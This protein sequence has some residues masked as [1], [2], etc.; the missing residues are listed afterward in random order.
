MLD[1]RFG[2][3]VVQLA[4]EARLPIVVTPIRHGRVEHLLRRRV[5]H[6]LHHI[7]NR[8]TERAKRSKPAFAFRKIARP[9]HDE[10][11]DT[12]AC[13]QRHDAGMNRELVGAACTNSR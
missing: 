7:G 11:R 6:R 5:G 1:E 8:R 10:R 2:G 3:I 4:K 13:R 9:D 12:V